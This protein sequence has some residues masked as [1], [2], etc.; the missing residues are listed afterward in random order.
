M[1]PP[2]YHFDQ[3]SRLLTACGTTVPMMDVSG[4]AWFGAKDCAE[5]MK[6]KD[7]KKAI[8]A[9][10]DPDWQKT[11]EGLLEMGGANHPP[12]FRP[13]LNGLGTKWP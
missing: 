5:V 9:H 3:E 2:I 4:T 11:L 1:V 7:S 10:V 8:K 12:G 13:S 6:Y